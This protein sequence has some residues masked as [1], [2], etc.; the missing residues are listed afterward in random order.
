MEKKNL[1]KIFYVG[2]ILSV[3]LVSS[4]SVVFATTES[5][6]KN[7]KNDIDAQIKATN[8]E[9]AGVKKKMTEA[10]TQI[11]KLNTQ[12]SSYQNE[13]NDLNGQISTLTAQITEK[14]ANIAEQQKKYEEQQDAYNK[15]LVALYESGS[16]SYLD[17]LLSSNGLADFISKYYIISELAEYDQDLLKKIEATKNQIVTEKQ[18]L[19]NAKNTIATSKEQIQ[20]KQ[21]SLN[22]SKNDK[23][24]LVN[25][26][27]SEEK[28]LNEQLEEFE[29]DKREIEEE[30]AALARKN[31]TSGVSVVPSAAGYISPLPGKTKR[32]ITMGYY[33]YSGH[34]GV[35]FACS[36]GTPIVAVKS[37]TVVKSMAK[38]NA[39]GNYV[40]YGEHII[41]DHGDGTM[42]LY[43]HGLAGSRLVSVGQSVSQGQQIMSVGSTGNS[44]GPHLHFEVYAG[45]KRTNPTAFLP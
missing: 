33:G 1:K 41:I 35:D 21:N 34:G 3:L 37:G 6:L 42:T 29:K 27:S 32:N 10:L 14:E 23:N 15:R 18:E 16:T 19:E 38:K 2:V 45:G 30:I 43:A 40:S 13:I 4:F 9:I 17:M 22:V 26:L 39:K 24:K 44:T 7:K 25:N 31:N 20:I 28:E 12:I 36:S 8:S 11:N 5:D